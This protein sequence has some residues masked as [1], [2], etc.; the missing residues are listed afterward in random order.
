MH[1]VPS[2]TCKHT[3]SVFEYARHSN[4]TAVYLEG[5]GG[6][7]VNSVTFAFIFFKGGFYVHMTFEESV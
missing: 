6:E 1:I 4:N 2:T 3:Y 7:M 5:F